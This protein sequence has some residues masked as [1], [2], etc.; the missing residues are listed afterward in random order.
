[1]EPLAP[2][3]AA[4]DAPPATGSV[5]R[6]HRWVAALGLLFFFTPVLALVAGARAAPIENRRLA[7]A[8]DIRDGWRFFSEL[9]RWATDRLPLRAQAVRANTT[10]ST[11]LFGEAPSYGNGPPEVVLGRGGFLFLAADWA[12]ACH[13]QTPYPQM[14]AAVA[15]LR[16]IVALAGGRMSFYVPPDKTAVETPLLPSGAVDEGC[17]RAGQQRFWHQ[18]ATDPPQTYVDL[19]GPLA[20][21]R[22][23]TGRPVYQP[24]DSHWTPR[25]GALWVRDVVRRLDPSLLDSAPLVRTG[26]VTVRGDLSKLLGTDGRNTYEGWEFRRAGV[27]PLHP[28]MGEVWG[29][30]DLGA[31][32]TS[33]PLFGRHVLVLGDSFSQRTRPLFAPFFRD[34]TY[35]DIA[36]M[37]K[38]PDVLARLLVRSPVVVVESAERNFG[39]GRVALLRPKTLDALENSV[40]RELYRASVGG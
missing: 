1:M 20:A 26:P 23:R 40:R 22:A 33:A 7:P 36:T 5:R 32:T 28:R 9:T 16:S 24:R 2:P 12:N 30:F 39:T 18:V 31:T 29:V 21:L 15:R 38:R 27:T 13:P 19:Y 3:T 25:G 37:A 17:G 34:W 6:R 8:P 14:S 10:L 35:A 4:T 11:R